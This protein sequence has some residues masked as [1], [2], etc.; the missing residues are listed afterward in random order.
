MLAIG[1]RLWAIGQKVSRILFPDRPSPIAHRL[2]ASAGV[3]YLMVMFAIMLMGVALTAVG[4]QWKV[5][6]QREHEAELRF[7]GERIKMAIQSYAADYEVRKASRPNRYPLT[8]EQLTQKPKRYLPVVY[9]DPMTGQDFELIKVGGE[10]RGVKSRSTDA[11]FDQVHFKNATA[12]NQIRFE[13]AIGA[14]AGCIP[15]PNPLNPLLTVPCVP[16]EPIP[17]TPRPQPR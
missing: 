7:R 2:P 9:K 6:V 1:N 4:K 12:Y 10:V 8:L 5:I 16:T 3:T 14:T 13:V 15:T 11:P 17:G